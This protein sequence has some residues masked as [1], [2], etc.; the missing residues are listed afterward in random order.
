MR[1]LY[2]N[3]AIAMAFVLC[4]ARAA[5]A[6]PTPSTSDESADWLKIVPGEARFYVEVRDLAGIRRQF[7]RLGIWKTVRELTGQKAPGTT[8]RPWQSTTEEHL[9]LNAETAIHFFLGRRAALIATESAQWQNGVMLAELEKGADMRVW[10]RR[11]RAKTLAD[12][13]AVRRYELP[14]GILLAIADRTIAFGPAGDP[15][16]LWGRTVLLLAGRRGP[17]LAGRAEFAALRSRLSGVYPSLLYVVWPDGDPT[18]VGGCSRLL[19]GVSTTESG[20]SCELRGQRT[21]RDDAEAPLTV[22]VLRDLPA[23]TLAVRAG[24]FDF[25]QITGR[26]KSRTAVQEDTLVRLLLRGLTEGERTS[27]ES[28][29]DLGPEYFIVVGKDQTVQSRGFDLPAITVIC[30]TTGGESYVAQLDRTMR[31]A[32]MLLA[33]VARPSERRPERIAVQDADCDGVQ[34]HHVVVGPILAERTGFSFLENVDVCWA[35]LDGRLVLSTSLAH[36]QEIV[37][38]ARGKMPKLGDAGNAK[39]LLPTAAEAN[40]VVEWWFARGSDVA[41]MVS[42]WLGYW[43]QAQPETLQPEWWQQWATERLAHRAQLG[44]GLAADETDPHRAVVKEVERKSPALRVLRVGDIVVGAAGAP[45]STSQPA[46]EVAERY[47]SRRDET[48]FSLQVL[49]NGQVTNVTIP[50]PPTPPVDLKGFD[51]VRALKQLTTLSSHA[52]SATVW[53]YAVAPDRFDAR[54][55]IYWEPIK[56][57]TSKPSTFPA[58]RR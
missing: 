10:L 40:P 19:V 15:D 12:E 26:A 48:Q 42:G 47:A 27:G 49:R 11:W 41:E 54:I 18:A 43:K 53:R 21:A 1:T 28:P 23:A 36:V 16:G 55:Q 14:G 52:R 34:L 4:C 29:A 3:S 58:R 20:I 31:V 33:H 39:D 30:Q 8:T 56:N 51:P 25:D 13:G 24:S 7:Q 45:L 37:R 22:S 32:T 57:A 44:I 50:V 2:R 6:E 5:V 46:R 9:K 38:A 35:L 17:T